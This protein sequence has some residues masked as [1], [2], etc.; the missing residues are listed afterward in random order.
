MMNAIVLSV[1]LFLF[2]LINFS[3]QDERVLKVTTR[4]GDA[5]GY[6]KESQSGK[7]YE[8]YDPLCTASCW[9]TT[10]QSIFHII[11]NTI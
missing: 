10:I 8:A 1:V 4:L 3:L 5:N 6:Y 11:K 2:G 9:R 7:T